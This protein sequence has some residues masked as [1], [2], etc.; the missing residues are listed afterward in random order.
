M[1]SCLRH[2]FVFNVDKG[3]TSQQ[4]PHIGMLINELSARD[5][6][7]ADIVAKS[8]SS[9]MVSLRELRLRRSWRNSAVLGIDMHERFQQKCRN[10]IICVIIVTDMLQRQR[11]LHHE[12]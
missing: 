7:K 12:Y 10:A 2:S 6:A 5:P 9:L 1:S 11:C 3:V 4:T 8:I